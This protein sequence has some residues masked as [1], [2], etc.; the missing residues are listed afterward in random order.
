MITNTMRHNTPALLTAVLISSAFN[1][2]AQSTVPT[3]SEIK[4]RLAGF[5][6][7]KK[8]T[9]GVAVGLI[10]GKRS[11]V[12]TAGHVDSEDSAAIDGD[13]VF[14][15]GSITKAFTAIVLQDM[16][17]HHELSLNDPIGKFLPASVK[18]P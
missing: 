3:D 14:E 9:P 17:D 12:F 6:G 18:T 10:D 13:T 11:R 7:E 5:V 15:I 2:T 8:K 16:V 4:Q 1:T